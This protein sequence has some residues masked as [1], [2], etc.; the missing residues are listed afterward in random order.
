MDAETHIPSG[1]QKRRG[2]S[3]GI[4]WLGGRSL[5]TTRSI[6]HI[7]LGSMSRLICM[8]FVADL[9][10][11]RLSL[12]ISVMKRPVTPRLWSGF[13]AWLLQMVPVA[14]SL[15]GWCEEFCGV[16]VSEALAA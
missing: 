9:I 16:R 7:F 2:F 4:R 13:I 15:A 10:A 1:E 12:F 11:C 14:P 8:I 5:H 3:V 6:A